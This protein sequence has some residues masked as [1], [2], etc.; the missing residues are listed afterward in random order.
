MLLNPIPSVPKHEGRHRLPIDQIVLEAAG[1]PGAL[2]KQPSMNY[3]GPETVL[4]S[5]Q[6]R[7]ASQDVYSVDSKLHMPKKQD[8]KRG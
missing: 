4:C 7:I 6:S 2:S 3:H 8:R 1:H 5:A